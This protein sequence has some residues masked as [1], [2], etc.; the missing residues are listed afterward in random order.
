MNPS[1]KNQAVDQAGKGVVA[2]AISYLLV[3]WGMDAELVIILMPAIIV[4]L[5]FISSKI[6]DPTIA[7][8]FGDKVVTETEASDSV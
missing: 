8:F 2:S 6:G 4:L 7:S 5:A 3:K 1:I